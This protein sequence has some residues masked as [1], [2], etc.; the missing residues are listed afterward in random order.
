MSEFQ[1]NEIDLRVRHF[2]SPVNAAKITFHN[3]S[4]WDVYKAEIYAN[5]KLVGLCMLVNANETDTVMCEIEELSGACEMKIRV[6]LGTIITVADFLYVDDFHKCDYKPTSD[7][8]VRDLNTSE[9]EATDMLGRHIAS[10]ED[11]RGKKDKKV[12]IFYWSWRDAHKN[13]RPVNVTDILSK[14][15]AAEYDMNHPAWGEE[16]V[17]A[18]WNEPLYGYYLNSDD[19]VIRKH[20]V[21]LSNAGVDFIIFDCTNGNLLWKDAYEP[22][23]EGLHKAREEG[24]NVP[25]VAF[26]LNF[27]AM[28]F[29]EEMLRV[30]YQDLYRPGKYSDLWFMIDGKPM[31]MAYPES[32]PEVGVCDVDTKVLNEIRE[33]FTYRPGMPGYGTGPKRPDHWPWLEIYPQYK[34]GVR[35]DG[36]CEVMAVGVAQ[37]ANKDRICTHFN[38]KDTYGRSYTN[39]YGFALLDDESY[40]YGYNFQEQW[41]RALDADPDMIFITGWNEW[42]MMR[43]PHDKNWQSDINSNQIAMVDQYD[44]EHSRDIEPDIDGYLDTYYLQM[45][46]N[47]RRFKGSS[48]RAKVSDKK[49]IDIRRGKEQWRDVSPEYLNAKGGAINRDCEGYVGC[50]YTNDTARNNIVKAKVARDDDYVYF[51]AECGDKLTKSEGDGWMTLYIDA[52]RNK[53]TGWEGYDIAINRQNPR[54]GYT[55][56][57]KQIRTL[58]GDN[59]YTWE[60]IGKAAISV[61]N[62]TVMI[63]VPK[64]IFGE[65]LNFEF[66]WSDNM[67]NADVMDFYKN[68]D[69]APMGRFNYLF[70]E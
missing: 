19:Y 43:I 52:D 46:H 56:I 49:T 16:P 38:D 54:G 35:D 59:T 24:I 67:Q 63:A 30:L 31:I 14:Y 27:C 11:T 22:I 45:V 62:N 12:G 40:K 6:S 64:D 36:S 39:E 3:A 61:K 25:K 5:G 2:N 9:W 18:H 66:K 28:E 10:V 23:L 26:M 47:I 15:P 41:E 33:F 29:T 34:Y 60:K 53:D 13:R 21:M 55:T 37:N 65:K 44:R 4:T 69:C 20:A 57:E 50:Y 58:D 8:S 17:Q 70:K 32:I 51:Y 68:G 48:V 1:Y 7:K 42:Q